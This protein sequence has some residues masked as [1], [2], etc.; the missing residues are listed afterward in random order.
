M[1]MYVCT[2]CLDYSAG[3]HMYMYMSVA[4]ITSLYFNNYY[5]V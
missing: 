2:L 4:Q 1:Y 5:T 3:I